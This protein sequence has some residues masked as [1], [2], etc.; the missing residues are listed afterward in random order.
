[1][2]QP[3]RLDTTQT[4]TTQRPIARQQRRH[5]PHQ[6]RHR[7]KRTHRRQMPMNTNDKENGKRQSKTFDIDDNLPESLPQSIVANERLPQVSQFSKLKLE[8]LP[9]KGL[10]LFFY[11]VLA[12]VVVLSAFEIIRV[13][14]Y[15]LSIHII[16]AY[17]F[18]A[19]LSLVAL[20]GLRVVYRYLKD[21]ENLAQL[22][23]IQDQAERLLEGNDFG[24]A[25]GFINELSNF[26]KKK[27]TTRTLPTLHQRTARLQQRQRNHQPHRQPLPKTTRPRSH[28]TSIHLLHTNRRRRSHQPLGFT[29]H[30][31]KPMALD[32]NDRRHRP[33][34]RRPPITT[35][36]PTPTQT[37]HQPTTIRWRNRTAYRN[38]TRRIWPP[39]HHQHTQRPRRTRH[40]RRLLHRQNRH[41]R[42]DS[43][44]PH[45]L[46]RTQQTQ[47]QKSRHRNDQQN[48]P[49]IHNQNL[50]PNQTKPHP[51]T[52]NTV[53]RAS[54]RQNP[55][56]TLAFTT[57]Q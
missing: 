35:Q 45:R 7:I 36:P 38:R 47:N 46:Y 22:T 30:A 41:S 24:Q 44:P 37:R 54:A 34:L 15:A 8:A 48:N 19:L 51:T 10:K 57:S 49:T 25:Q 27:T 20:F 14:T 23:N 42:H 5:T 3:K 2:G 18:G 1:M 12:L 6:A 13:F 9:L 40:R 28:Q 11:S 56:S 50:T 31:T 53:G 26:Y 16:V 33:S 52:H 4:N 55:A 39:R 17:T 43:H 29:R 32:K 21:K